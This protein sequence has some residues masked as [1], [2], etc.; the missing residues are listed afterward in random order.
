[1]VGVANRIAG[2]E[3]DA[4]MLAASAESANISYLEHWALAAKDS[5]SDILVHLA[6]FALRL[7]QSRVNWRRVVSDALEWLPTTNVF[8]D[9]FVGD[10]EEDKAAWEFATS[11]IRIERG[12]S[13][14][15]DDLIQGFALRPKEPPPDPNAVRL[16]TIHAAKGLEF[17][18]VW[19]VGAAES[20]LPSWQSLKDGANPADLEE[21]RNFFVAIT[22]TRRRLTLTYA[23]RYRGWHRQPSRFINEMNLRD[24]VTGSKAPVD[25]IQFAASEARFG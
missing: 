17:E 11:A 16:L 20:I 1:M 6:E 18:N 13:P 3:V 8:H 23:N 24:V 14:D 25:N 9:G 7:V 12:G 15:L 4:A 22:R 5:D 21:E 19:L 10:V 2:A